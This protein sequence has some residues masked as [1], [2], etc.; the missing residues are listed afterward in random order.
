M[1]QV[2]ELGINRCYPII[3]YLGAL[4]TVHSCTRARMPGRDVSL[5]HHHHSKF[6]HSTAYKK[7]LLNIFNTSTGDSAQLYSVSIASES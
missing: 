3:A 7:L 5:E 1:H 6:P 4:A 2:R